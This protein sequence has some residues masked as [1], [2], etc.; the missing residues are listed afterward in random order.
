MHICI[1][2]FNNSVALYGGEFLYNCQ[3]HGGHIDYYYGSH[4]EFWIILLLLGGSTDH[5]ICSLYE[6]YLFS[7][8]LFAVYDYT[9]PCS[10]M[11]A[12]LDF[13]I[14]VRKLNFYELD[15]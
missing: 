13:E 9:S 4:L 7:S 10:D 15:M 8:I 3:I 14:F 12:I 6:C 1:R 11:A 2:H 5:S